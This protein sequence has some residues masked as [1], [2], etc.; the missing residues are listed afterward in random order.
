MALTRGKPYARGALWRHKSSAHSDRK[1]D[2]DFLLSPE[3][4]NQ[5][6]ELWE[7]E[8]YGRDPRTAYCRRCRKPPAVTVGC[9]FDCRYAI[10]AR[11]RPARPS[12]SVLRGRYP[13]SQRRGAPESRFFP[14][15]RQA[16]HKRRDNGQ[17][18]PCRCRQ[19]RSEM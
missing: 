15:D 1:F 9:A 14:A 8:K 17:R 7:V 19:S 6:V 10:I 11:A 13:S 2:R 18:L 12:S 4:R 3:K 16:V 5:V